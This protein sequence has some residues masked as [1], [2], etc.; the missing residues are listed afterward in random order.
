M[1][2]DEIK[3][4]YSEMQYTK[5]ENV[6]HQTTEM[7]ET[8][9]GVATYETISSTSMQYEIS[10]VP[11]YFTPST[12]HAVLFKIFVT[13]D[14]LNLPKIQK[15][16][17]IIVNW[18]KDVFTFRADSFKS[19][20][21]T[22]YTSDTDVEGRPVFGR[23]I[24]HDRP[25][26]LVQDAI[27]YEVPLGKASPIGYRYILGKLAG[28]AMFELYPKHDPTYISEYRRSGYTTAVLNTRYRHI[29]NAL[30]FFGVGF[31]VKG[32]SLDFNTDDF[33][34]DA[35]IATNIWYKY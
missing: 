30:S 9:F 16:D 11:V 6:I 28:W 1:S 33:T 10:I 21:Y 17:A 18:D 14:W 26:Q 32:I 4:L 15:S 23:S 22:Q 35:A 3:E 25:T 27:G 2:D 5:P 7:A 31:T 34:D 29:H 19:E 8:D 13:F 12:G 20:V 24:K